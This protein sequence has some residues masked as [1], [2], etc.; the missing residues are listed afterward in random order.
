MATEVDAAMND[1]DIVLQAL[2]RQHPGH[3]FSFYD[4]RTAITSRY[5]LRVARRQTNR[6]TLRRFKPGIY[7]SDMVSDLFREAEAAVRELSLRAA[8]GDFRI[9]N[10]RTEREERALQLVRSKSRIAA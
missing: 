1:I 5:V 7:S 3:D 2:A 10:R 9:L 6:A 4:D 8:A